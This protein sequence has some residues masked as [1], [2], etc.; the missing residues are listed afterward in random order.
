MTVSRT[1]IAALAAIAFGITLGL[2]VVVAG[3]IGQS[4]RQEAAPRTSTPAHR[5]QSAATAAI[6]IVARHRGNLKL[7]LRARVT[8]GGQPVTQGRVEA[9]TDMQQMPLAHRQ[10]PIPMTEVPGEGG[11]YRAR[12]TVPMVGDYTVEVRATSP[13]KGLRRATVHVGDARGVP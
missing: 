3:V 4:D 5:Q 7:D 11:L 9:W 2:A 8:L 12:T 13:V 10:G 6:A 1:Y